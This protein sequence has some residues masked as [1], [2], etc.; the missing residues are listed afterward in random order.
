[1]NDL[2]L[3]W[4]L[5]SS[6]LLDEGVYRYLMVLCVEYWLFEMVHSHNRHFSYHLDR[7]VLTNGNAVLVLYHLCLADGGH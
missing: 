6:A 3:S 5:D 1:M 4:L 2:Y 7:V